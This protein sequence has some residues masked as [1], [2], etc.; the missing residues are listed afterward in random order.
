MGKEAAERIQAAI[1][2]SQHEGAVEAWHEEP[3]EDSARRACLAGRVTHWKR[4]LDALG[5]L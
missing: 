3:A 1:A 4:V 2:R 5:A